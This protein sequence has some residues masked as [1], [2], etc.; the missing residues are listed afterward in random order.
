LST[1]IEGADLYRPVD[2]C[3]ICLDPDIPERSPVFGVGVG[4]GAPGLFK[5]LYVSTRRVT[6]AVSR[7][8]YI[9]FKCQ[10][11]ETAYRF[12]TAPAEQG[13][14]VPTVLVERVVDRGSPEQVGDLPLAHAKFNLVQVFLLK[15]I[16]LLNI[17]LVDQLAAR[18]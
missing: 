18:V 4:D 3:V 10:R 8:Q 13:D 15:G 17:L 6:D 9:V 14:I 5:R 7:C 11:H 12:T 2:Y 16:A 1:R